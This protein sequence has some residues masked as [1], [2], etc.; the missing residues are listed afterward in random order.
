MLIPAINAQ[1]PGAGDLVAGTQAARVADVENDVL[2]AF[3]QF[4]WHLSD[5][6]TLQLGGRITKDERDGNRTL[7]IQTDSFGTLPA[8][9]VGAPLVYANLFGISST[10]LADLGPTGAFFLGTLGAHPVSG[11]RDKTKF[12]PDVKLVWD[13]NDD[14]MLYASWAR[15][16]KSGSF[17]FRANNRNFYPDMATSFEF[18]DEENTNIELGGKFALA[19]GAAELNAALFRTDF[20]DL[21][22]SIFDGIL[23]FNVGNAAT[24]EIF[25]LEVDG[26]WAA[27]ENLMISGGFSVT[28]FEFKDFRN[29]QCYFGQTPDVDLNGDGTPELCDYT[30]KSNQMLSDFQANLNF[31]YSR[32]ITGD[33]ELRALLSVFYTSEYDAAATFDPAG[34]QDAYSMYNLRLGFG[35]NTGNWEIALLGKNLSDEKVLQYLGDLP[36]AGSTFGAKSNYAFFGRG[37]TLTLQGVFRF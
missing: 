17:D 27:T 14:M 12:S 36:L 31:D 22:I 4:N 3:A 29:G 1:S 20:D 2:S 34:L 35:P 13:V 16:F 24:A 18:E 32:P 33:L 6:F 28:D 7:A 11:T 37:R 5:A 15:G 23:G 9:Q 26:R 30:G 21:Q 19:G 8:P 10:N 25:G